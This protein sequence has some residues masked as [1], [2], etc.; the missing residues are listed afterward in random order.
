MRTQ[1]HSGVLSFSACGVAPGQAPLHASRAGL[2]AAADFPWQARL[3]REGQHLCDAVLV[4]NSWLVSSA[5]CFTGYADRGEW[6]GGGAN[7]S[8]EVLLQP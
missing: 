3:H 5:D 8:G 1:C 4:D 6:R 2:A 7:H